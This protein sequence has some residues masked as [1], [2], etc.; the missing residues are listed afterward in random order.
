MPRISRHTV[1]F[2]I[3]INNKTTIWEAKFTHQHAERDSLVTTIVDGKE[4]TYR[5]VTTE[6]L[7]K[8]L[9]YDEPGGKSVA[10][11]HITTCF[12][13]RQGELVQLRGVAPCSLNDTYKWQVGI[14]KSFQ[15]ALVKMGIAVEQRREIHPVTSEATLGLYGLFMHSFFKELPVRTYGSS[16]G[17]PSVVAGGVIERMTDRVVLEGE[18]LP[19]DDQRSVVLHRAVKH[20]VGNYPAI[21]PIGEIYI[22]TAPL[23]YVMRPNQHGLGCVCE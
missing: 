10:V 18:L 17:T 11:Q 15:R 14:K 3:T 6:K 8:N 23:G 2:P 16:E 21:P 13:K 20:T 19:P 4:G 7:K 9:I 5:R 22:H 1:V 12:L